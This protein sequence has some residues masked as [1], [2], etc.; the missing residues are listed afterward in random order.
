MTGARSSYTDAARV[1]RESHR[2]CYVH[3]AHD[4]AGACVDCGVLLVPAD[5][6]DVP[7]APHDMSRAM[8]VGELR[9]KLDG[10][11][12]DTRV[13]IQGPNDETWPMAAWVGTDDEEEHVFLP[14]RR[15]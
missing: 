6:A 14:A 12:S 3:R 9:R 11:G 15:P 1:P 7:C 4:G 10:Y 8:T 2:T 13:M 5:V